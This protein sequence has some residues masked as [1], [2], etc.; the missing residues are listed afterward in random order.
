MSEGVLSKLSNED[1][2]KLINV[3]RYLGANTL[4]LP[5][6]NLDDRVK[7]F[8]LEEKKYLEKYKREIVDPF[9]DFLLNQ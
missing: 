5:L 8:S 4:L 9:Q 7:N 3:H 2:L 1:C 6:T